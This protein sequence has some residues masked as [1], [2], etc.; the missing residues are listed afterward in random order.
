[1]G[2][3]SALAGNGADEP[4]RAVVADADAA[5][6]AAVDATDAAGDGE[7]SDGTGHSTST[8]TAGEYPAEVQVHF[9][10]DNSWNAVSKLFFILASTVIVY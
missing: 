6:D 8:S 9:G 2:P 7:G 4:E 5:V 1:M 3:V 10:T